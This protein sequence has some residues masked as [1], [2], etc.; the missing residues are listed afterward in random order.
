MHGVQRKKRLTGT[1]SVHYLR[2]R[3]QKIRTSENRIA[4]ARE[5][6]LANRKY[7]EN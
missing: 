1:E 4:M 3:V 5:L 2:T 7:Y 6:E